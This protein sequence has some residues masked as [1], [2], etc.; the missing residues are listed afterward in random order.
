MNLREIRKEKG[1]TQGQ[2]SEMSS[3]HQNTIS[4]YETGIRE[5]RLKDAK[6]LARA[7]GCT[8]DE[9]IGDPEDRAPER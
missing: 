3:I 1:M 2:L 9:L 4:R 8:V 6:A 5:P 7:L